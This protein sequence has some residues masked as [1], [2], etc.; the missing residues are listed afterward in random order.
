MCSKVFWSISFFLSAKPYSN[1]PAI[2]NLSGKI[3]RHTYTGQDCLIT[4]VYIKCQEDDEVL[5]NVFSET[6]EL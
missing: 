2:V 5:L 4:C 1:I 6:V 3:K